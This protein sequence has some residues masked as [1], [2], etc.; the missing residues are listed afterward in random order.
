MSAEKGIGLDHQSHTGVEE[1][2]EDSGA[3]DDVYLD[4]DLVRAVRDELDREVPASEPILELVSALHAADVADLYEQLSKGDRQLIVALTGGLS[5]EVLSELE[6]EVRDE[7]LESIAPEAVAEKVSELDSDDAVALI[8]DME[9]EDRQ[10]VLDALPAEDRTALEESLS[11]PEDSAGRMMQR[12][13]VAVP[14]YWTIGQVIDMLRD[15]EDL[16]DDFFEVFVIEADRK[17][18]GTV[19]LSHVMRAK[20]DMKVSS[21]MAEEQRFIPA[22]MDQEEVAYL[23][24]Q[25][26]LISCAVVDRYGRLVGMITADDIVDV[27]EE[28]AEEDILALGGV[29]EGD[30]NIGIF[31]MARTRFTWLLANLPTAILASIVIGLF[32]SSIERMVALAVLM[33]IV[34][35]MGG[36]AGTQ[37]MTVSVRA[38]A[39]RELTPANALRV[40]NKEFMV[41]LLNGAALSVVTGLVAWFWFSDPQLGAV[42]AIAMIINMVAAGLAGILV[43]IGL[44]K[45]GIDPA[46]ASSVFVTT[47]TD[48]VGFF[49]FLG[50]AAWWLL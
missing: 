39:T 13:L 6:D 28:E 44:D 47:I 43:P 10:A 8:E 45:L 40:I 1:V 29:R 20:R 42:I 37:T 26:H 7:Y 31:E 2:L 18:V 5:A 11:F 9:D 4:Q 22:E 16:P 32:G 19:P 23:F 21:V 14:P 38:L 46:I 33:P 30:I 24:N 27:V 36:N 34:A 49:A 35:S 15:G 50:L 17:P 48:V 12:E 25:Y 41:A 3:A